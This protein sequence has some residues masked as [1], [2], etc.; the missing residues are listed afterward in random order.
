MTLDDGGWNQ[1]ADR[2]QILHFLERLAP[3]IYADQLAVGK[4]Q[5]AGA[6]HR[7]LH[8][9]ERAEFCPEVYVS[10]ERAADDPG[11][12]G[13]LRVEHLLHVEIGETDR[14]CKR[15][16]RLE[17]HVRGRDHVAR[18]RLYLERDH[19]RFFA[20]ERHRQVQ[21]LVGDI[22]EIA[23]RRSDLA[24]HDRANRLDR[25]GAFR[26]K[27]VYLLIGRTPGREIRQ[28]HRHGG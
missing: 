21:V 4:H 16:S 18:E 26:G 6:L 20:L 13:L 25:Y 3:D 27:L 7:R 28:M 15:R 5:L 10:A 1:V 22:G 12:L 2:G 17:P 24:V 11:G 14:G 23:R 9:V 19:A 8:L